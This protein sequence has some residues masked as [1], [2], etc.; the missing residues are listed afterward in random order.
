MK[1]FFS[2]LLALGIILAAVPASAKDT[3]VNPITKITMRTGPGTENKIVAMLVSGTRLTVMEKRADWSQV[4]MDNGKVG[5]VLT[6]FLT[7][8]VPVTLVVDKLRA[9][10]AQLKSAL[11]KSRAKTRSL[12]QANAGLNDINAKYQKL[13]QKAAE[14]LE[15]EAAHK[16]LLEKSKA[17]QEE[18]EILEAN[19]GNEKTI[20]FL[21][22][23]GVFI[24]GMILGLS[25]RKKKHS[26]LL[27]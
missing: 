4:R 20:W 22:G 10:N 19:A 6:R 5:W 24:V 13:R 1:R 12:T 17:Q 3:Y 25:T 16:R 11:E 18:I 8:K 27:D 9:E 15:L 21:S 23:A 14:V 2:A 7:E 26:S